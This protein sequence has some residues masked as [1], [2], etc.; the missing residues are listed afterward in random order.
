MHSLS[1][2]IVGR[3]AAVV[4]A[5]AGAVAVVSAFLPA[6]E[7]TSLVGE[8][9]VGL[10]SL[11]V[12][13]WAWFAPW[14]GWPRGRTKWLIPAALALIS[15]SATLGTY[16]P[17]SYDA[18]FLVLFTW[19][20]VSQPRGTA[21]KT[22]PFAA[23]AYLL[24]ILVHD[25]T[26]VAVTSVAEVMALSV[27]VGE[28][29]SWVSGQLKSA[30]A[31]DSSRMW[32]MQTLL[33]AGEMLASQTD[34][35][36]GARLV[37]GLAL[38]L[39][40]ADGVLV[41]LAEDEDTL[42]DAGTFHWLTD[43]RGV[44]LDLVGRP[45]LRGALRGGDTVTVPASEL[46]GVLRLPEDCPTAVLVPMRGTAEPQGLLVATFGQRFDALDTFTAHVARTFCT[47]A[48]L[49]LER[50]HAAEALIAES[51]HDELTGL[52][53][54]KMAR[55][56]LAHLQPNDAVVM[57]DLDAFKQ[58]ND[59]LG[60]AAGD[61][62]LCEFAHHLRTALREDD[63]AARFGGDEFLLVLRGAASAAI[64]TLERLAQQWRSRHRGSTFS[65]GVALHLGVET[66]ERTLSR[67]DEA[68]YEAKRAGRDRV[69]ASD[70]RGFVIPA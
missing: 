40:R 7:R 4:F 13:I 60:H 54:R 15:G 33:Q 16:S 11:G 26:A 70:E 30:E 61:E 25:R 22:V 48:G 52:G 53:N 38:Q 19:I 24:P 21:A 67:A 27:L 64:P 63:V 32:E 45:L 12:G 42:V 55:R 50:L 17:Y 2:R 65:T 34:A 5:A 46:D 36:R 20:G 10:C 23:A 9:A 14:G 18:Y 44:Q 31:L 1:Q 29:L 6:E 69:A 51:L 8:V 68:L 28:T 62:L 57:V 39:L 66:P 35:A 56:A 47:Q 37:A 58:V 41:L 43:E 49:T 59:T 3:M